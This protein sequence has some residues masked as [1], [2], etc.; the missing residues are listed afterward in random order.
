MMEAAPQPSLIEHVAAFDAGAQVTAAI[1]AG[2]AAMLALGEGAIV[3]VHDGET[4]RIV[5]HPDAAILV[6]ASDGRRLVTGGD[7]GR[8]VATAPDGAMTE[9]AHEKGRWIDALAVARGG[10]LA[11]SAGKT[12][13]ARDEKGKIRS[14]PA[15]STPQGLAFAPKG[16]RLAVSH[17]NGVSLWFPNTEAAPEAL[18]WKGS[19][20][21]VTWSP[22]GRFIVTSMQ[23]NA[24]HG[25]RLVP[26]KK[27]M[28][29]SGYPAKTRSLSWSPDGL[30]LATSGADAVIVWGFEGKDG[31]MGK[32]P[33]ECGVRPARVTRVAFHPNA[34]VV[35]AG[36]DDGAILMIRLSDASELLGRRPEPQSS[37]SALAWDTAGKRLAFGAAD[38]KAGILTL[39]EARRP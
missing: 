29:M 11:W 39:P 15:P 13:M 35:A 33:R 1:F 4:R 31:P 25:W 9:I 30:W 5:A 37:I 14:L 22:D 32:P 17:Y 8:V 2:D 10:A 19:H 28:R 16:Y 18:S 26:D 36:Y 3:I 7:D 38:G 27:D 20:L 24:L 6:A 21:D 12:V 34:L 23:E